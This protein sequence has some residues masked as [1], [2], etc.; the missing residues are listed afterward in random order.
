MIPRK[1]L[2][3]VFLLVVCL[4]AVTVP[5]SAEWFADLFV[6]PAFTQNHDVKVSQEGITAT[7]V[8]VNFANSVYFGGRA[9]Y[10]FE[11]IPYVGLALD[12]SHFWPDMKNQTVTA[13]LSGRAADGIAGCLPGFPFPHVD[14]SVTGISFDAMLRLPLL[15]TKEIPK[16]RLQPYVTVGPTI[17]VARAKDSGLLVPTKQTETDTSVGVKAGAGIAWQ[18]HPNIALF[19]EYRF[20]HFAPKFD[21]HNTSLFVDGTASSPLTTDVNTHRAVFGVSLRY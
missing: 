12:V 17:F 5:A 3:T 4:T 7:A 19:G 9:G 21:F 18:F 20:T 11:S 10:W 6:G 8:D 2:V 13:C 16:G 14:L 15:V 1:R